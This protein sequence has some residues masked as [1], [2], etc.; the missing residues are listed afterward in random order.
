MM[1]RTAASRPRLAVLVA[2]IVSVAAL[3]CGDFTSVPASLPTL[4]DSGTVYALNGAPPGAPTALHFFSGQLLPA[5]ANFLFDVAFDLDSAGKVVYLPQRVVASA[6]ASTHSVGLRTVPDSFGAVLSAPK[7]GYRA[8]TS[9]V[10]SR[11]VV[12]IA[13][14]QDV[15]TCGVSLTGSTLYAKIV[16]TSVDL[17]TRQLHVR[18][19]VD[20]NCGFVSF[21]PGIPKD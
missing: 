13:Q 3:A 7:T 16:V 20:P 9:L 6:L 5:D 2:A 12:V 11:N 15:S 17:A 8:D 19:T 18:F 10:T 14:S 21:A 4:T 1:R